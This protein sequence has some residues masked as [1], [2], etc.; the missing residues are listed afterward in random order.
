[1]VH[2]SEACYHGSSVF[3]SP[4]G[5]PDD[6]TNINTNLN[7]KDINT[8]LNIEDQSALLPHPWPIPRK[9]NKQVKVIY[10][11]GSAIEMFAMQIP[12]VFDFSR[13]KM[14]NFCECLWQTHI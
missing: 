10:S 3:R 13:K 6:Q 7:I 11:Y 1:M 4:F 2:Y 14:V 8:N 9:N 5:I 12:T